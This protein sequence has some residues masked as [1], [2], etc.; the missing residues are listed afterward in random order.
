MYNGMAV[1]AVFVVFAV[2]VGLL[3]GFFPAVVLSGFQ[4]IKVLKNLSNMKLF[5]RMG[6]RKALLVSQF[7]LSLFFILT[8]LVLHEQ[9][10]LFTSQ[11]HGFNVKSNI[12]VKLNHTLYQ[13][14]KTELQKYGN[15]TAVSA[16]SHVPAAGTSYGCGIKKKADDPVMIDAGF[17]L[18]DEDYGNNMNLKLL[19]GEF[20]K[21]EHGESN[22]TFTV[23]NEAAVKKLNFKS[24]HD[25]IGET[26]L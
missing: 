14:L 6:M 10:N 25:A 5:S 23:I 19:A 7:T 21:T 15:I 24:A 26:L 18:V 2:V 8:V 1:Y 13:P 22:K 9:L 4:P 16:V 11:D 17:F 20:F 12:L 3:A